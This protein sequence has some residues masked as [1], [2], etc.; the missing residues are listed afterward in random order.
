MKLRRVTLD[1]A[2]EPVTVAYRE[3]GHGEPMVLLHGLGASSSVWHV[4]MPRL[5][6]R[7]RVLALDLPGSGRSPLPSSG[8]LHGGWYRDVVCGFVEKVAGP[9]AVLV[10]HSMAGGLAVL[11]AL[12]AP[13]LF[14]ALGCVAPAGLGHEM[15]LG[16]RL[17]ALPPVG[18]I[19]SVVVPAVFR[20]LG[21]RRTERI[22]RRRVA[23]DGDGAAVMPLLREAIG[24]YADGAAVRAH[25]RFLREVA[26]IRGQRARYQVAHRLHELRL[27]TLVV[28]G[29]LDRVL[30]V[31]QARRAAAA[32]P[33]LEVT[34]LPDCGHTPQLECPERLSRLLEDFMRRNTRGPAA[35]LGAV[36]TLETAP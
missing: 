10:G 16:L 22:I 9:A 36:E 18:P 30:P 15:P 6:Q 20:A 35:E 3:Q 1:L 5:A 32:C 12:E 7:R 29:A 23:P 28:W 8:F 24:T 27:P 26:S 11:A 4:L 19:M 13:H 33:E 34:V 2:G 21:P 14:S 17:G 25:Y 31:S